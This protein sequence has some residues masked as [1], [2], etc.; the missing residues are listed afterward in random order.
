MLKSTRSWTIKEPFSHLPHRHCSILETE[1]RSPQ[2]TKRHRI[3]RLSTSGVAR[4]RWTGN[5]NAN[6]YLMAWPGAAKSASRKRPKDLWVIAAVC[7]PNVKDLDG[8]LW[9][10]YFL[11]T[12]CLR[13]QAGRGGW[14]D[15]ETISSKH[16]LILA[17]PFL[18]ARNGHLVKSFSLHWAV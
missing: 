9:L 16:S 17:L 18:S 15:S 2:T 4:K 11:Q 1:G 3:H 7:A 13:Q 6:Q 5:G 12:V 10:V 14:V 8:V